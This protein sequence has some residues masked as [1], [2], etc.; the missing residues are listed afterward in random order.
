MGFLALLAAVGYLAAASHPCSGP[1]QH[2]L[3]PECSRRETP[4]SVQ[5]RPLDTIPVT[6]FGVLR[7]QRAEPVLPAGAVVVPWP[8]RPAWVECELGRPGCF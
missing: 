6:E 4:V 3:G 2:D 8:T 1:P 7:L 5:A